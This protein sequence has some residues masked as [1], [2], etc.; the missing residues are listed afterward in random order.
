MIDHLHLGIMI[1]HGCRHSKVIALMIMCIVAISIYVPLYAL[2]HG[3]VPKYHHRIHI[4]PKLMLRS[5]D[6][7]T[8]YSIFMDLEQL[9]LM[10]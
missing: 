6:H 9:E 1:S 3:D 8:L 4:V 10:I 2:M 7:L 5:L